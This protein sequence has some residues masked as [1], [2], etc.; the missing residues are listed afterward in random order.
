MGTLKMRKGLED[1]LERMG[2]FFGGGFM[3]IEIGNM[4]E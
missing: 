3:R 2:N 1:I 4:L